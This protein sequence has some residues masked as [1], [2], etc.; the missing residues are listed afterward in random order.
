[1]TDTAVV[2][3]MQRASGLARVDRDPR[4]LWR[5]FLD[6]LSERTRE[7][8]RLDLTDFA[9]WAGAASPAEAVV[10]F[11]GLDQGEANQVFFEY[12]TWLKGEGK[13]PATINRR[14]AAMRSVLAL[15]RMMG[16]THNTLEIKPLRHESYRDT[17]GP[18]MDAIRAMLADL[19][20]K[21]GCGNRQATRDR[22]IVRLLFGRGLRVG[23][24]VSLDLAHYDRERSRVSIK[25]KARGGREWVTVPPGAKAAL[26]TWLVV[27][28]D[29]PGPMFIGL[30]GPPT[31]LCSRH[32]FRLLKTHYGINPHGLRH[33]A[34]TQALDIFDGDVTKVQRFSRHKSV[35][36]LQ[37][38]DDRRQDLGGEVA[39]QV[40]DL[41]VPTETPAPI[42]EADF[43]K[44]T[45]IQARRLRLVLGGLGMNAA[46][47]KDG[48]VA[49]AFR[50]TI[51]QCERKI[52]HLR[53][54]LE[55]AGVR[56]SMDPAG[57]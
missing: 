48:V 36:V 27:R 1:M 44:L 20:A 22:A 34:I 23:E 16:L 33:A 18:G 30:H 15:A 12:M 32:I 13:S 46:A 26:D 4:R 7:A 37:I 6:S 8:Y 50:R 45:P 41:M 28:G 35:T 42:T 5:S 56:V 3:I 53:R 39:A 51:G 49:C 47:S 43:A 25:G 21:A 54:R 38:Y 14:R 2:P 9:K 29:A 31:R 11:I 19:E 24:V 40:D 17:A 52:P 55:L 10:F 57:E